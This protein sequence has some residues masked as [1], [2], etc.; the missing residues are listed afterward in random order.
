MGEPTHAGS[1]ELQGLSGKQPPGSSKG[2]KAGRA[3]QIQTT[4]PQGGDTQSLRPAAADSE[5]IPAPGNR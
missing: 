3:P 4:H 2:G 5:L 1:G